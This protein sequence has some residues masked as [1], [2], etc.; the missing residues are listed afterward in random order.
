MSSKP[1]YT[2]H[3]WPGIP[4]RGEYVRLAFEAAG[5]PYTD[6]TNVKTLTSLVMSPN[7]VGHPTHFAPPVLEFSAPSASA[8]RAKRQAGQ[9]AQEGAAQSVFISQTPAILAYLGPKLGLVGDV[10]GEE[11]AV[12]EI[13]RAQ[14]NQ[15]VLTALDLSNEAH[16]VH[17]PVASSLY[18][19]DQ[20]DESKRRADDFRKNRI[21]KFFQHFEQVL[22]SNPAKSH[23]LVGATTTTADLVLFHVLTGIQHAFP[24]RWAALEKSG[25]YSMLFKMKRSVSE[26]ER[27]K[28]YL[29]SDR[30]QEFGMGLFRHYEELDGDE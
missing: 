8:K 25:K 6:D 29:A 20:K 13:R 9:S 12:R 16:D 2:L 10:E 21:P 11:D 18:Y 4:G 1:T 23:R 7:V 22:S 15:L 24:R 3:Y 26:E 17:H 5:E 14:V 19:E 28:A 27:L 30:R